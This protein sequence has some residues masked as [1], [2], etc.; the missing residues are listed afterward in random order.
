M[1]KGIYQIEVREDQL[2]FRTSSFKPE[3]G[4][5][6]HSG[7]YNRELASILVASAVGGGFFVFFSFRYGNRIL[8]LG[9]TLFIFAAAF[10]F[11]RAVIFKEPYLEMRL[12]KGSG[13]ASIVIKKPFRTL[14]R[15]FP[16]TS[17]KNI[18]LGHQRFKS[19]NPDGVTVVERIALQHGTVIPGF[20]E[21]RD[22]FNIELSIEGIGETERLIIFTTEKREEADGIIKT[23]KDFLERTDVDTL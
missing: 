15:D 20:G 12:D 10:F 4:S 2:I 18:V 5:I 19:E 6:L 23:I 13:C 7:I 17:I 14:K 1:N 11:F 16:I 8:L 3:R 21:E 22:L 9:I